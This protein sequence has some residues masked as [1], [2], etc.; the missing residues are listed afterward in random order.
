MSGVGCGGIIVGYGC[1]W[2][3]EHSGTKFVDEFSRVLKH[4]FRL[5]RF[6]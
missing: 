3:L 2:K 4:R 5:R 1:V 6:Q